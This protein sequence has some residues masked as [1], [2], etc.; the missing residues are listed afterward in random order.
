LSIHLTI[1]RGGFRK[2]IAIL[3]SKL[4]MKPQEL[5]DAMLEVSVKLAELSQN[6]KVKDVVEV[7]MR[8]YDILGASPT[9]EM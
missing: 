8:N 6:G 3:A 9:H 1:L 7:V 2:C 5:L 4:G